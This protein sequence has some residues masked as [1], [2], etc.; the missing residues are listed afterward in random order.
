MNFGKFLRIPFNRTTPVAA[1]P[2]PG[3]LHCVILKALHAFQEKR[4]LK[5]RDMQC[6]LQN[7]LNEIFMIFKI[8]ENDM[9]LIRAVC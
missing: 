2:N 3:Y 4:D 8:I 5:S 6:F 1:S 9:K 7:F